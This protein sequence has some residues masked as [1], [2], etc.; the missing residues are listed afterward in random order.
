MKKQRPV[1]LDLATLKFPPMAIASI[2]HR[3]SGIILFL[4][5]PF[6]LYLLQHSLRSEESF[7]QLQL[8]LVHPVIKLLLWGFLS[9]L[10]YHLLAGVRHL[11]MDFGFGETVEASRISALAVMVMAAI[12]I[13][14]TGI[15]LW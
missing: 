7:Q 10:I 8:L 5:I 12:L 14:L 9:A 15:W 11:L 4:M 1:N 6:I 2:L 13:L 3:I